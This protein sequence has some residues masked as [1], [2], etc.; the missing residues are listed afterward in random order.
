MSA[1]LSSIAIL[2]LVALWT[3]AWLHWFFRGELRHFLFAYLFPGSW[4]AGLDRA[5]T[6]SLNPTNFDKFLTA[7]SSAPRFIRGVLGCPACFSAYVSGAGMVLGIT[8]I[9]YP[10]ALVPLVWASAA[11]LGHQAFSLT[12]TVQPLRVHKVAP[13]ADPFVTPPKKTI[14][15][16]SWVSAD[17]IDN[18]IAG[19]DELRAAF[20]A[21]RAEMEARHAEN[22]TSCSQCEM[23]GLIARYRLQIEALP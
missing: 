22:G 19:T 11:W 8:S 3:A 6:M 17:V 20:F 10:L 1:L 16:D 5:T 9:F 7:K 15:I 12:S 18:P 23:N 21:D 2:P 14:D 4:R 13:T